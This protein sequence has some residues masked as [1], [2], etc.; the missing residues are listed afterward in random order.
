MATVG[1]QASLAQQARRLYT[2]ELV[3]GLPQL[4][5]SVVVWAVAS[6]RATT[7]AADPGIVGRLRDAAVALKA[8]GVAW[9]QGIVAA[10]QEALRQGAPVARSSDF[11]GPTKKLSLVDD[12]T[13][14]REILTSRLALAIMDRAGSEFNDLRTRVALLE[15]RDELDPHDLLRTHVLARI[16]TQSWVDAGLKDKGLRDLQPVLHEEFGL[17]VQEAYHEANSWLVAQRVL[18]DIDLRPLIRR[19]RGGA[20]TGYAGLVNDETR[21]MTRS[22]GAGAGSDVHGPGGDNAIAVMT[23]LNRMIERQVPAFADTARAGHQRT[24]SPALAA[25]IGQAQ[26]GVQRRIDRNEAGSA[27]AT[28]SP[29]LLE[30]LNL[31]KQALKRAAETPVERA[32]IEIVALLFQSILTEERIPS[33]VRV[34]FARLQMPVLRVAVGEPD[35]FATI[36]HPARRLID[37]MGACVM[38]FDAS[39]SA[40]GDA[41]EGEIKRVVQVV[42]AYPDTG[43]RVFQ[44]V[45]TEFE[46]F[47]EHY[48]KSENAAT[49]RG[50]SLAQQVEQ[51]ETLAIQY[52]I[53]LRKML[54]EVPVQEGVRQ[55]LFQVWADVLA[56]AAVR[57]GAQSD[58]TKAMRKAA[59]DLIWSA[60]AKVSREE[61]ADVI[62]RLPPLLKQLREGMESAGVA[63]SKRDEHVRS[64][65]DSLAAAF[66]AKAAAIPLER[67]QE[68]MERLDTLEEMLPE[69]SDAAIDES[70]VLDLSGHESADL[71]VVTDGGSMPTPAMVAWARELQVGS[72]YM[73]DYRGRSEAVQLA[74]HGLR[75]QLSLFVT[76]QGRCVL[77]QQQRLASFLQ[78]GLLL[79]AQD[80]ALTVRATRSALAK[81]DVDSS[82][83]VE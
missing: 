21:L 26:Q 3:K 29:Q 40:V 37:R 43:R 69:A 82:Y 2:E 8:H 75:T 33:A 79:P 19:S 66:S 70:V 9:H 46:R 58:K 39:A 72:W 18:P 65:N 83:L 59:T 71:E 57:H 55:F 42:E 68:L 51:R 13:M 1:D 80:E 17:L 12:E 74:W 34:W 77:F 38:G 11:G 76:T 31:R 44:T 50:V 23:R 36:D 5:T 35:F 45:L 20:T 49:K 62:R 81:L 22:G 56:L 60:G 67:L 6:E 64:L 54:N 4:V 24:V 14:D 63:A 16:V 47:L 7:A 27:T 78:A 15:M 25:A 41:L 32:T 61:R 10:M 52:T 73:L 53:E 28:V 48:F 30:E